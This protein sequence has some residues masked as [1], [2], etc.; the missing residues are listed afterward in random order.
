MVDFQFIKTLFRDIE[1][2]SLLNPDQSINKYD[3]ARWLLEQEKVEKD[4]SIESL[5]FHGKGKGGNHKNTISNLITALNRYK[6][7]YVKL[8]LEGSSFETYDEF[9]FVLS[10]VYVGPY[11]PSKLIERH[12]QAKPTGTEIIRRLLRKEL[13][14]EFPSEEDRRSKWLQVTEEGRDEFFRTLKKV[15]RVT[16]MVM[17]PLSE[18]ETI[19]L[20]QLLQKLDNPHR[21]LFVNHRKGSLDDLLSYFDISPVD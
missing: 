8:A 5:K 19:Q 12:I 11:T 18:A 15:T 3:F 14:A 4:V 17:A 2:Y 13:I 6:M 9:A 7:N 21:D 16:E 1:S 20:L 10:L